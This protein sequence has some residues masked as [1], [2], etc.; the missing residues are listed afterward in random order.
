MERISSL[1]AWRWPARTR[2]VLVVL[3]V[4]AL[5]AT[6]F[7]AVSAAS[8]TSRGDDGVVLTR[9]SGYGQPTGSKAVR[10]LQRQ[11][12]HAGFTPG[13]V[14]GL[15]GARTE[16]A[17]RRFQAAA[18]VEPDGVLGPRTGRA[19]KKVRVAQRQSGDQSASRVAP[20]PKLARPATTSWSR[21]G[22]L[23]RGPVLARGSGY[24]RS[25]AL[26][27][28]RSLQRR[29]GHV[30]FGPGPV[31]GLFGP[32]TESAVRRF[33][34]GAGLAAD[35][36]V[37][38][39]T[40]KALRT[41]RPSAP[42][43]ALGAGT[44]G[45]GGSR[46]VGRLQRALRRL[47]FDP[48]QPNGR[49]GPRTRDAVERFQRAVELPVDGVVGPMTNGALLA[50]A[51]PSPPPAERIRAEA[52]GGGREAGRAKVTP[53][54]QA[55]GKARP[56][57]GHGLSEFLRDHLAVILVAAAAALAAL[58]VVA[59][60]THRFADEAAR[61]R[62]RV[63]QRGPV[64]PARESARPRAGRRDPGVVQRPPHGTRRG[65]A[66]RG[67][68]ARQPARAPG[69]ALRPR[70]NRNRRGDAHRGARADRSRTLGE[71]GGTGHPR[72]AQARRQGLRREPGREVPLGAGIARQALD[73]ESARFA[74][75]G[76]GG[77][78]DDRLDDA[79]R[80]P[81]ARDTI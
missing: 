73:R 5:V 35:G 29:L 17:L 79:E 42:T 76:E 26:S 25:E 23:I 9:G 60:R 30:G 47:G 77:A 62:N 61:A 19:L 43:V 53:V 7:P 81:E 54:A 12:R 46:A 28:V 16:A 36:V 65:R 33:Q 2:A 72:G 38:P 22:D 50:R 39:A 70:P 3:P 64:G 58:L 66:R 51:A 32:M 37:G 74:D 52:R 8:E 59:T 1:F 24:G 68:I 11:L 20:L 41:A 6:V 34:A 15:F 44:A 75:R 56:G 45:R 4:A 78:A 10:V 14:D 40:Y 49:F 80:Q 57:T 13:P 69:A 21:T 48:G 31:D 63:R 67:P 18:G 27:V 71:A 55:T